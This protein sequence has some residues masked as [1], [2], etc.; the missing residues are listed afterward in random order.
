MAKRRRMKKGPI[1]V[2]ILLA[3]LCFGGF[4]AFT[5]INNKNKTVTRYLA[6]N[7]NEV[8][9]YTEQ[10]EEAKTVYRGQKVSYYINVNKEDMAKIKIDDQEF[11]INKKYLSLSL[12]PNFIYLC[13]Y[14]VGKILFVCVCNFLLFGHTSRHVGS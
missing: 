13:Y 14:S 6:S 9:L 8:T 1:R 7:T 10:L 5:I 2:L 12:F 11:F 4:I 3:V